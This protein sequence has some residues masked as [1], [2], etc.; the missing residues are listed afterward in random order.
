MCGIAGILDSTT[1]RPP[2]SDELTAMQRTMHHRGPD[3][4]GQ[5]IA[6]EGN[7]GLAHLRLA[8]IDLSAKASQPMTDV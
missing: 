5:W 3:G 8:V 4:H 6:P 7:V 1:Q 2:Q